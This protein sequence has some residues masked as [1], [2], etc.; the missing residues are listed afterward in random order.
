MIALV[1]TLLKKLPYR[2]EDESSLDVARNIIHQFTDPQ[3][4]HGSIN[5]TCSNPAEL[6]RIGL[7][8]ARWMQREFNLQV[9]WWTK[10][11]SRFGEVSQQN[12]FESYDVE[13]HPLSNSTLFDSKSGGQ[14]KIDLL[15]IDQ[16]DNQDSGS[17][18]KLD[19]QVDAQIVLG[20]SHNTPRNEVVN[21]FDQNIQ[22]S[23]SLPGHVD[24]G[25]VSRLF[26]AV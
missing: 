20:L 26:N 5:V 9:G 4:N 12:H 18:L 3:Y 10:D 25:T 7:T 23:Y 16:L 11:A 15:I 6:L 24:F 17:L 22:I 1:P 13:I 2:V 19:Q 8:V 14:R 21:C